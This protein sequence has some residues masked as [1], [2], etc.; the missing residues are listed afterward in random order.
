MIQE[1]L[2][3]VSHHRM[4]EL[5][6]IRVLVNHT[7]M[8]YEHILI[9]RRAECITPK[10]VFLRT[11]TVHND[12]SVTCIF[13]FCSSMILL[14][15]E[16]YGQIVQF[17]SCIMWFKSTS[18]HCRRADLVATNWNRRSVQHGFHYWARV[19]LFVLLLLFDI[20]KQPPCAPGAIIKSLSTKH[21]RSVGGHAT[22]VICKTTK[23][24]G[25]STRW[26]CGDKIIPLWLQVAQHWKIQTRS[27]AINVT[28][29][30]L[31]EGK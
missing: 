14:A 30:T 7:N 4:H 13:L 24:E 22:T 6:F 12:L 18:Q 21:W 26:C 28:D 5:I 20:N 9:S 31:Y 17:V 27:T 2:Y 3:C 29:P 23:E 11:I 15:P 1:H 16:P 25:R 10:I 19:S 8:V